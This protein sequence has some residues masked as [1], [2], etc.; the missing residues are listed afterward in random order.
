[1]QWTILRISPAPIHRNTMS[2]KILLYSKQ[3]SKHCAQVGW[4]RVHDMIKTLNWVSLG[5]G[6]I[7]HIDIGPFLATCLSIL[8]KR[9]WCDITSINFK[10]KRFIQFDL[11]YYLERFRAAYL[12]HTI[13]WFHIVESVWNG[14]ERLVLLHYL[15]MICMSDGSTCSRKF[16]NGTRKG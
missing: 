7:H 14:L 8:M 1:M 9:P 16:T 13:F 6:S 5:N 12:Y 2:F 11:S 10:I 3:I 15:Y 4:T